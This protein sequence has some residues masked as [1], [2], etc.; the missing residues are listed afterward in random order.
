MKKED[1]ILERLDRLEAL[2]APMA[3][4]ARSMNDFKEDFAPRVNELVKHVII[5]LSEIDGDFHL[6]DLTRLGKNMLRNVKN[7]DYALNQMK[8]AIDFVETAEPL[9]K[10]TVPYYIARMDELERK[11]VFK[12]LSAGM[13]TLE[14]L[15]E[16]YNDEE[17]DQIGKTMLS[18]VGALQK[19]GTP[20]AAGF[21]DHMAS[22]PGK[23]DLTQAEAVGAM[24]LFRALGNE[25]VK[26]GMGVL[27]QLTK[28]MAPA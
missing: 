22:I 20:E 9:M 23:V 27:L 17:I 2:M 6:S 13:G 7:M 19:L 4:S 24:D 11:G 8:N 18:L 15:A 16:T 14:K 26:K 1:E 25:E 10:I 21:V 5:E 28:A 12:L 3:E